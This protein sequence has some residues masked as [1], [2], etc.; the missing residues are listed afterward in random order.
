[1]TCK[2][3]CLRHKALK[4]KN[5]QR[6]ILGQKRCQIC[7]IFIMWPIATCPCCGGRLRT[8]PR[9]GKYK[10]MLNESMIHSRIL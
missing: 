4:P 7:N 1:M 5:G 9:N 2:G 8:R 3:I 10:S 6:Y